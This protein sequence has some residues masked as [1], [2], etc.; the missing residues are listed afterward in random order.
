MP[1]RPETPD[2]P[3]VIAMLAQL[4]AYCGELYPAESNH[5]MDI[6]SLTRSDVVF[7]VARDEAGRAV[8]CGACVNRGA[9]GEVKRMYV[10]PAQRGQGTGRK[11][12]DAIVAS[13]R[14]QGLACLK[15]ETGIYQPEAIGLYEKYGFT[16]IPP[17]GDYQVDPLSVFMEKGL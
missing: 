2:Q 3:E 15:L 17:F 6:A 4:D 12:L 16:Y 5:L 11:L 7:L 13:G 9:Y 8:G 14:T 10:D 1:I